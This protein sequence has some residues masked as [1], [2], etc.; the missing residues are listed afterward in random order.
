[1]F[2]DVLESVSNTL[3]SSPESWTNAAFVPILSEV[4]EQKLWNWLFEFVYQGVPR[5]EH[6][7]FQG[8]IIKTTK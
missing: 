6:Q 4:L 1:M 8:Q 3:S 7:V 5:G 2:D